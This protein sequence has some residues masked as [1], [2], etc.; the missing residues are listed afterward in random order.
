MTEETTT[1]Q[2]AEIE[3]QAELVQAWAAIHWAPG[4][5]PTGAP[6][7]SRSEPTAEPVMWVPWP[8]V[9]TGAAAERRMGEIQFPSWASGLPEPR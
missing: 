5:T 6:P 4:A 1:E 2:L 9:S 8:E 7:A 3:G